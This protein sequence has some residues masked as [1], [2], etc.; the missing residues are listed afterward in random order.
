MKLNFLRKWVEENQKKELK[1][2]NFLKW[3]DQYLI[4]FIQT[5]YSLHINLDSQDCFPFFTKS[6]KMEFLPTKF[7]FLSLLKNSTLQNIKVISNDRIVQFT[8]SKMD[9]YS[10]KIDYFLV[11]ELIPR[12]MNI[13]LLKEENEKFQILESIKKYTFAQNPQREILP[14]AEYV[15]PKTNFIS[16]SESIN[17]P[18]LIKIVFDSDKR[19]TDFKFFIVYF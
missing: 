1:F 6:S 5:D 10:Q 17:F 11:A 18:I 9:I 12:F 8:F 7:K 3:R 15:P 16:S 4:T 14:K 13:I 19:I 2:K